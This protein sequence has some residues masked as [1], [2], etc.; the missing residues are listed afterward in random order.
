M[1]QRK[2]SFDKPEGVQ[3]SP[4]EK[5]ES[6]TSETSSHK[7]RIDELTGGEDDH[8]ME[9]D[10]TS[11]KQASG[12]NGSISKIILLNCTNLTFHFFRFQSFKHF[13]SH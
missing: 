9:L 1:E 4:V 12:S 13:F 6:V 3:N 10:N 2:N 8:S 11:V 7:M 5:A